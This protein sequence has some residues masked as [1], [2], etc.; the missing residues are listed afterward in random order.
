MINLRASV[1]YKK[2]IDQDVSE[3]FHTLLTIL[4]ALA[5]KEVSPEPSCEHA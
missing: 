4:Q 5:E 1:Q 2:A 3:I